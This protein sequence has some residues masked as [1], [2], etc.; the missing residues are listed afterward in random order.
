[1][2]PG[3]APL[4]EP[5]LL[6]KDVLVVQQVAANRPSHS[7]ATVAPDSGNGGPVPQIVIEGDQQDLAVVG[8]QGSHRFR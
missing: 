8:D 6:G 3:G 1:M 7:D 2:D 5:R 4:P